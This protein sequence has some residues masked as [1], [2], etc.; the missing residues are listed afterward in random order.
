MFQFEHLKGTIAVFITNAISDH[1]M[2]FE[3]EY[4]VKH[5][6]MLKFGKSSAY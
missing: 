2:S 6:F 5:N 3:I 1:E 4:T